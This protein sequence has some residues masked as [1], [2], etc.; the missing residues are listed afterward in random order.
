MSLKEQHKQTLQ[1]LRDDAVQLLTDMHGDFNQLRLQLYNV[2]EDA[3]AVSA[4][5]HRQL[6][7]AWQNN[8][9]QL[10]KMQA[11]TRRELACRSGLKK[12]HKRLAVLR[13]EQANISTQLRHDTMQ[14]A[15]M[16]GSRHS[17]HLSA[18]PCCCFAS[19]CR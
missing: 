1:R 16:V 19:H 15:A 5:L 3:S 7:D 8:N 17:Q 10:F 12:L 9:Q 2:A 18:A 4:R 6:T 13:G 14:A 11:A